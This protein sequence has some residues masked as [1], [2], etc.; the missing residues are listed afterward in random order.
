MVVVCR[1][2]RMIA[3]R[4][5]AAEERKDRSLPPAAHFVSSKSP[6]ERKSLDRDF[7]VIP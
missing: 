7:H 2:P 3:L 6:I 1:P 4:G 5:A